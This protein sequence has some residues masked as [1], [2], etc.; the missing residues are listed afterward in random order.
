[1]SL[2][3]QPWAAQ[4]DHASA[5]LQ[6]RLDA[7]ALGQ[8][9]QLAIRRGIQFDLLGNSHRSRAHYTSSGVC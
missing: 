3:C 8:H 1:M 4:Q 6:G 9:P 7:A 2:F 5:L